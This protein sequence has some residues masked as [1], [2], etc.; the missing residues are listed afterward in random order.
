MKIGYALD[1]FPILGLWK[2]PSS[3]DECNGRNINGSY[4]YHVRTLDQVE[5]VQTIVTVPVQL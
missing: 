4:Q 2:D 1:G 3:L 5:A